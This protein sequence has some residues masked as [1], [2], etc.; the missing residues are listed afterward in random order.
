M[1]AHGRAFFVTGATDGIGLH[2][3]RRLAASESRAALILHGRDPARLERAAELVSAAAAAASSPQISILTH[4]CDLASGDL[5]GLGAA[6]AKEA[7]ALGLPLTVVHNAGVYAPRREMIAARSGGGGE[8]NGGGASSLR[9]FERTWATNVLAPFALQHALLKGLGW[10]RSRA[11][12]S[13]GGGGRTPLLPPPSTPSGGGGGGVVNGVVG[14]RTTPTHLLE[15]VV[16]TSSLSAQPGSLD[17]A[18]L[19]G[20]RAYS[21]HGAYGLSKACNQAFAA[22]LALL[23]GG[24]GIGDE[25]DGPPACAVYSLDPGTVDT[26]MLR[27]GWEGY[28]GVDVSEADDTFWLAT[29]PGERLAASGGY[30][31]GR[32]RARLVAAAADGEV[33]DRLWAL[34]REQT[35]CDELF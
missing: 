26:K 27:A 22:R 35:G 30:F 34:W 12:T 24:G 6:V 16:V 10:R 15:R 9:S 23:L 5:A 7:L 18:N 1:A 13:S 33:S 4:A 8:S 11:D 21:P 28:P 14:P 3:A 29:A 20:E 2:T 32:R 31:V 17:F 25:T 19:Q